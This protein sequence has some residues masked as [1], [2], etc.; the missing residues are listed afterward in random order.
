MPV[1]CP[2][3]GWL[4]LASKRP[5]GSVARAWATHPN[6]QTTRY[7]ST[8]VTMAPAGAASAACRSQGTASAPST[9]TKLASDATSP[10]GVSLDSTR[11][12]GRLRPGEGHDRVRALDAALDV[13]VVEARRGHELTLAHGCRSVPAATHSPSG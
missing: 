3:A 10:V 8:G 4:M 13:E 12:G 11:S 7:W 1:S 9:T 5:R 2:G 6:T